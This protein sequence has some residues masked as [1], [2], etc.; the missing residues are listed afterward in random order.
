MVERGAIYV[1]CRLFCCCCCL[2]IYTLFYFVPLIELFKPKLI[3]SDLS[4]VV[5]RGFIVFQFSLQ[6]SFLFLF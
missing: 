5:V 4:V 1:C 3:D 6:I 2:D